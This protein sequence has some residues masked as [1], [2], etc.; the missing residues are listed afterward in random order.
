[1]KFC[2][3]DLLKTNYQIWPG[4][5]IMDLQAR[6]QNRTKLKIIYQQ[7]C[8]HKNFESVV[9]MFDSQFSDPLNDMIG[10]QYCGELV[11]WS[12]CHRYD[13]DNAESVQFAWNY[14]DPNLYLGLRSLETEC[15]IYREKG[16][17]YLYLGNTA[18]Y[19]QQFDG[20]EVVGKLSKEWIREQL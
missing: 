13:Q 6:F 17:K 4:S 10:Y 5:F 20:F 1:M 7:Y 16:Y 3:I 19:K 14:K 12:L 11:A 18:K 15:A 8:E 9:P 2:R